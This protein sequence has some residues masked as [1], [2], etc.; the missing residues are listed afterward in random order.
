MI[1]LG[2]VVTVFESDDT[3]TIGPIVGIRMSYIE[4]T[5]TQTNE[6]LHDKIHVLVNGVWH[7]LGDVELF[8]EHIRIGVA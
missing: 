2:D 6:E 5:S 7:L 4:L 3:V 8:S 1:R